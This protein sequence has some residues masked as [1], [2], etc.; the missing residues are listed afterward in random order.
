MRMDDNASADEDGDGIPDECAGRT[1]KC[2]PRCPST[3][4]AH[5]ALWPV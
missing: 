4:S 5:P 2:T 3:F 1:A